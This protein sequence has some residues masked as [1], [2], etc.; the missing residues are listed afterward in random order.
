MIRYGFWTLL[1]PAFLAAVLVGCSGGNELGTV[2]AAGTVTLNGQPVDNAVV[3]FT[4]SAPPARVAVARTDESGRFEMMTLE[5]GDGV[6]P[7]SYT[8]GISKTDEPPPVV[9]PV[10]TADPDDP[11]IRDA[12]YKAHQEEIEKGITPEPPKDLLPL[13]YKSPTTSGLT[14]EIPPGGTRDLK[15]DLTE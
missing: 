12:A 15:F 2:P 10:S 6:M 1:A 9:S 5:P 4:P 14:A 7:G 8:V 11:A 13:K 3:T